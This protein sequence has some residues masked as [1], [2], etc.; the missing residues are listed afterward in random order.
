MVSAMSGAPA[1]IGSNSLTDL[2]ARIRAE[3]EATADALKSSVEHAMAAGDLLIEAKAQVKHGQ[4]LPWLTE[5]C[6]MSDRTARLYMQ[7][8]RH[9]P[10]IEE[11]A[12]VADLNLRGAL[13]LI[14]V[15]KVS[16]D[17]LV[18]G[19]LNEVGDLAS[20]E[21]DLAAFNASEATR[22][23]RLAAYRKTM[24]ALE[25]IID[26]IEASPAVHAVADDAVSHQLQDEF[27]SAVA[28]INND[29]GASDE[30][31]EQYPVATGAA[32]KAMNIA[33]KML[34]RVEA[35]VPA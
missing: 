32:T 33:T 35:S 31:F 34:R 25:R 19:W 14:T 6:A 30:P 28:D 17:K 10:E 8:A 7:L 15:P 20:D 26:L 13:A 9:R 3:H 21:L 12:T 18:I 23:L 27:M 1:G 29:F 2:A 5:H 22:N 16:K 11:S 4:W 24:A